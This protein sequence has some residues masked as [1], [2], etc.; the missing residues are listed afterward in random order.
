[1]LRTLPHMDWKIQMV[2][3]VAGRLTTRTNK[4][5]SMHIYVN[6]KVNGGAKK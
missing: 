5:E 2:I 3:V 6:V 1:M 4:I